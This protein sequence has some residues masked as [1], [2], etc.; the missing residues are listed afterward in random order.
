MPAV[1]PFSSSGLKEETL[2]PCRSLW[3]NWKPV[4]A[5]EN[6]LQGNQTNEVEVKQSHRD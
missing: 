5:L 4:P 6:L 1:S 3:A 2:V